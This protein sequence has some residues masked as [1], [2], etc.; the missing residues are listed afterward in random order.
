MQKLFRKQKSGFALVTI[1]LIVTMLSA[2]S[3]SHEDKKIPVKVLIL[4]KFEQEELTGDFPGEA[5]FF[6][7]G[8]LKGGEEYEIGQGSDKN[9]LYYKDGIAM[10]ILGQGKVNAALNTSAVLSDSRFDLSDAYILSI[11][12]GGAAEG[13]AIP[14]DVL[15]ITAIAD[16][17]LG[18]WTDARELSSEDG[19][20]WFHDESFDD[21]A[22]V[23]L[24]KS[25]TDRV[26]ELTKN[27]KLDTTERTEAFIQKEYPGEEWADRKPRV[28]RG[29]SVTGD[30]YW[31]G[32]YGHKTAQMITETYNLEDP[33]AVTEME[34]LAVAQAAKRY[35]MLDR[36]IVLRVGVNMDVF[37]TGI[38]PEM[39][40]D[41]QTDDHVASEG[42]LESIDIFET[43][44]KNLF[45]VGKV[46]I[47]HQIAA[48]R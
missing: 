25:L 18:H 34:D 32:I 31:K 21:I 3:V 47:D 9:K 38:S 29:S 10:C 24:N 48:D 26:F 42:S 5:Q 36:L 35:G 30:Q 15:V 11:G 4:P 8:Y 41:P 13:Y 19:K 43:A 40:W 45:E 20:T 37:P 39:I 7:D 12:C 14:G 33:F 16:F 28:M 17:D 2:C 46:V 1:L 6:F 22:F 23:K 44:M 27:V